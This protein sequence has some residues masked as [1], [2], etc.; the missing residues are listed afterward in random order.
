MSTNPATSIRTAQL[1]DYEQVAILYQ[2]LDLRHGQLVP[3]FFSEAAPERPKDAFRQSLGQ[4]NHSVLVA[5][6][7]GALL[8]VVTVSLYETPANPLM[9]RRKR[10][11]VDDLVVAPNHDRQGI[12]RSLMAAAAAWCRRRGAEQ[13]LLTVWTGNEEADAFYAALG[14]T[15]L[16]RVLGLD[17]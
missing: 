4:K 10:G 12:G 5:E 16:N 17:L 1:S 11:Y 8:G 7:D 6:L 14:Y 13:L 3:T 15:Q 9:V 2:R